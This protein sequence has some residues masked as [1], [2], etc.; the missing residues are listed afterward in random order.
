L[1]A[2]SSPA[3]ACP[4]SSNSTSIAAHSKQPPFKLEGRTTK[5]LGYKEFGPAVKDFP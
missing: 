5:L 2:A 4:I 3:C 1:K